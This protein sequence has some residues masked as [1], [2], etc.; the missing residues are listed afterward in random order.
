[1]SYTTISLKPKTQTTQNVAKQVDKNQTQVATQNPFEKK[2]E[3]NLSIKDKLKNIDIDKLAKKYKK[4]PLDIFNELGIEFT[5]EELKTIKSFITDEKSLKAFLNFAKEEELTKEDIVE[6]FKTLNEMAP[7]GFWKRVGNFFKTIF[8]DGLAEAFKLAQSE[9]VYRS[10]KMSE[11]MGEIR[12]ERE[13]FSSKGLAQIAKNTTEVPEIKQNTMHFVTKKDGNGNHIYS[14]NATMAANDYMYENA[15][16]ADDFTAN[17]VELELIKGPNNTIKFTGDTIVKVSTRMTNK[18]ELK[19]T[20]MQVGKK[21][22]MTNEYFDGITN[23]LYENPDMEP[24]ISYMVTAK[25]QDGTDRF[26]AGNT[27]SS[28]EHLVNK[29]QTYCQNYDSNIRVL[30]QNENISGDDVVKLNAI[31]TTYP[32]TRNEIIEK[33]SQNPSNISKIVE[34]YEQKYSSTNYRSNSQQNEYNTII[35]EKINDKATATNN[36]SNASAQLVEKYK[37]ITKEQLQSNQIQ[38]NSIENEAET[39]EIN[40]QKYSRTVVLDALYKKFGEHSEKILQQLEENPEF[41]NLIKMY[42]NNKKLVAALADNPQIINQLKSGSSSLTASEL[43]EMVELCHNQ[44]TLNMMKELTEKY[45]ATKAIRIIKSAKMNNLLAETE[46][47]LNTN[48]KDSGTK[49]E[50]IDSLVTNRRNVLC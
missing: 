25:K 6:G 50:E 43:T 2:Q 12:G 13:D 36:V 28:S 40:G 37:N 44:K 21:A 45:G 3:E 29:N 34:E 33:C 17:A 38:N 20:M 16:K 11:T 32:E 24:T 27:Y 8:D 7:S 48:T 14:E 9:K 39:T 46:N 41:V 19:E 47:I 23:N 31:A 22:D 4:N 49:K 10:E 1:M 5:K 42:G 30:A 35:N 18:P 26:T 15:A